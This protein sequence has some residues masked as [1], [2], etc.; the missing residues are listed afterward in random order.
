MSKLNNKLPKVSDICWM[1]RNR[2]GRTDTITMPF[3]GVIPNAL[4]S[5]RFIGW[6]QNNFSYSYQVQIKFTARMIPDKQLA[7]GSDYTKTDWME[8]Y[9]A[10]DGTVK[11]RTSSDGPRAYMAA[12]KANRYFRWYSFGGKS[13]MTKGSY[14][15]LGVT[16]RVRSLNASKGQHGAWVSKQIYVKCKP[17]VKVHKIVALADGGFQIYFN[18]GGWKRGNS[19]VIL[20]DVRHQDTTKKQNKKNLTEEVGAIGTEEASGYPYAEFAGSGFNTDFEQNQK[21]VLKNCVFRTSDGVDVS[22]DGTYT[23]AKIDADISEPNVSVSKPY[24]DGECKRVVS[25]SKK[26]TADDWDKVTAWLNCTMPNGD[27]IR[28]NPV[29]YSGED[30]QER[31]YTFYPPLD[32]VLKLRV[33]IT[34]NLGGEFKKTYT[35]NNFS[36]LREI[37][38]N[39][40]IIVNYTDGTDEQPSNGMFN[41]SKVAVMNYETEYSTNATRPHEKELP[42]GRKRPIAFLGEGLEKTINLKGNIDGTETGE[43][44]TELYSTLKDWEEFQEYQGIVLVRLPNGRMYTALCTNLSIEQADEFDDSRNI[45]ITLEEI[46]I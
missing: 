29:E 44:T 18:T 1:N 9:K 35:V 15:K 21:I 43:Y 31:L 19:K 36:T 8:C 46:D 41:G 37:P 45:N 28:V 7:T 32:C 6:K 39:G 26:D 22:I 20:K 23:I 5:V 38:S 4:N 11:W 12:D 33:G 25:I 16:I 24:E 30:D 3:K 2:S 42:F 34:N 40:R 17:D 13:L 10:S 14:D 27:V